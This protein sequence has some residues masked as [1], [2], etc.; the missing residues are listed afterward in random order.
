MLDLSSH[1][2]QTQQ[3]KTIIIII[4]TTS[5]HIVIVGTFLDEN[6][7]TKHAIHLNSTL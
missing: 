1:N 4:I 5:F 2:K 7:T 3:Q 6:Y